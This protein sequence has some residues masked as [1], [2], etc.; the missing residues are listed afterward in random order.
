MEPSAST[1]L[2]PPSNSPTH[3]PLNDSVIVDTT[4]ISDST[5]D[6]PPIN[7]TVDITPSSNET[8]ISVVTDDSVVDITDDTFHFNSQM[9][10]NLSNWYAVHFH[11]LVLLKYVMFLNKTSET[12]VL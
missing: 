4:D 1:A 9:D 2:K 3:T 6:I 11:E 5:Q 7:V 12:L 8:G 10:V